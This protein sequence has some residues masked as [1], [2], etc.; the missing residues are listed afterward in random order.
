[1]IPLIEKP[2]QGASLWRSSTPRSYGLV[3]FHPTPRSLPRLI[4]P[5]VAIAFDAQVLKWSLDDNPPDE[6]ARHHIKE[7]SFYG[8]DIWTADFVIKLRAEDASPEEKEGKIK[9]NFVGIHEK[10]MWPGK[11]S[12]KEEGGRAIKL[13][14]DFDGWLKREKGG[15]FD[16]TLLGCVGGVTWV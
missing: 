16:A 13:L 4:Y 3:R 5:L 1:M 12:A 2:G 15:A 11:K 8:H 9:V 6:Y 7:A 10:A 14:E